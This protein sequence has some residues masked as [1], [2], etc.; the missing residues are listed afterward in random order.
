[1]KKE[2]VE[3]SQLPYERFMRFGAENLTEAE[4]LAIILR[5]G[6]KDKSALQLAEDVLR[7]F[8]YP[9]EGLNGL[10]SVTL[11]ELKSIK[12]IGEVK[13]VKLK[14]IAELSSRISASVAQKG[15]LF[16][17]SG[18]VAA[19]YMEKL[20]H[21]KTECTILLS[22]DSKGQLIKESKLS[23]GSVRMALI[24]AREI[25]LEALDT[26]AVNII[27]LHNHPSGD[28]TPSMADIEVT[29][30]IREMG[31]K[32]NIPLLDHIIIGDNRYISFM[33][34]D[35]YQKNTKGYD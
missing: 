12:G 20:R 23:E 7:L 24:S 32:M 35:W 17:K 34:N 6:T 28:P 16:T 1:M 19:Y 33:E 31:E 4:L 27:L 11:K 21:K 25:F 3:F 5:T 15:L 10:H 18:Q 26:K 14:C 8:K 29:D 22:L 2:N 30:D 9:N 13:A